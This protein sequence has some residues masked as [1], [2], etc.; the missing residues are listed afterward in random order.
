MTGTE[1]SVQGRQETAHQY[2]F[3]FW[4]RLVQ[5]I[6][7]Q[8]PMNPGPKATQIVWGDADFRTQIHVSRSQHM[9]T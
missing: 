5:V 6:G 3:A 2:W 7:L 9:P 4:K 1:D 8:K